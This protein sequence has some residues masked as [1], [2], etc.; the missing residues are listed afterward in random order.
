MIVAMRSGAE[1]AQIETVL[2]R[3]EA[4][5]Q[6]VHVFHGEERVVIAI[7]GEA[8]SEELREALEVLPGVEQVGRT[9]RPYKLASREVRPIG[10]IVGLGA[11]SLGRGFALGAGAARLHQ[12]AELVELAN[13]V[14][15]AGADFFWLGRPEGAEL[16]VVL[17]IVAEL[18]RQNQLPLLVEVWG[19]EE[20][21]PLGTYCDGLLVGPHHLQSYPLI[22]AASRLRRPVVLCRGPATSIEEWLL[23]AEQLLK[24][25]N[26]QVVL[27]EQGIRTFEATVRSTLDFS[28]V[29]VIK[30]LSHLP[31]IAN[32]SLAAGRRELVPALALGAA[33]VGADGVLVDVHL[34][35]SD[36]PTAGP[37]SLDMADFRQLAQRLE[38]LTDAMAKLSA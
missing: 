15:G 36:E 25:G 13:E 32:P 14:E 22:K 37:Q 3:I 23:V 4:D 21:D 35:P 10:T 26:F 33:G 18:R 9:T 6:P 24:G 30:R 20:I 19:P 34:G 27:C 28:A 2:R 12:A 7:L 38:S 29:A 8:P 5:G 1:R 31:I 16:G 17:P 11:T